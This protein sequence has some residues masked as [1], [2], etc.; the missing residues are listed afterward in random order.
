MS[1]LSALL[2]WFACQFGP[3]M[4]YREPVAEAWVFRFFSLDKIVEAIP[5]GRI[6]KPEE[7]AS[8]VAY[9]CS[10]EAAYI[11]RQVVSVN[12]GMC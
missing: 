4:H 8:L 9:L 7:V 10:P 6:G 11:T 1:W 5:A 12:G 3:H 2:P